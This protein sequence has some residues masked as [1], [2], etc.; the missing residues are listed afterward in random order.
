[1]K[2]GEHLQQLGYS[3]RVE[4]CVTKHLSASQGW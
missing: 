2:G 4:G 3:Q 1:M